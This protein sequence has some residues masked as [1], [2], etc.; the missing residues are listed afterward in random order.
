MR[1]TGIGP[2]KALINA[3]LLNI[4]L[5]IFGWRRYSQLS[6]EVRERRHA[7]EQ[8]RVLAET[9]P[10]TGLLNRRSF[11]DALLNMFAEANNRSGSVAVL[12]IDLDKFKRVNDYNGHSAG[13]QVLVECARRLTGLAPAGAIVARFGGDEFACVVQRDNLDRNSIDRLAEAIV[14][15]MAQPITANGAIIEI[16]A[17]VGV[18]MPLAEAGD[19]CGD[20]EPDHALEMADVA[21][22][23]AKQNGRNGHFWYEPRMAKEMRYRKQLEK[24]IRSGIL[25]GEFYPVLRTT[26]RPADRQANRLRDAGTLEFSGIWPR[27]SGC[28]HTHC[29]RNRPDR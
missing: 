3:L 9:D 26:D 23:H 28:V 19:I 21:M 22:Y 1:D 17:S 15:R 6:G 11:T 13:D 27:Q 18:T 4:A 25:A 16:T 2:D 5:I 14:D 12:M 10:L 24:G 29:R 7:E 20:Y 8:A